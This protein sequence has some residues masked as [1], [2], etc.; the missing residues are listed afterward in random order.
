MTH[1]LPSP[2]Y[3]ASFVKL[4]QSWGSVTKLPLIDGMYRDS[5]TLHGFI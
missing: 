1:A 4:L 2:I 3:S 5:L